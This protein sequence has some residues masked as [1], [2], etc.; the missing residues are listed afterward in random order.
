MS[1]FSFGLGSSNLSP[2][3]SKHASLAAISTSP[4]SLLAP[5]SANKLPQMRSPSTSLAA[6][7]N[8]PALPGIS[9]VLETDSLSE[10]PDSHIFERSVQD[11]AGLVKQEDY[12]PPALDATAEILS[13]LAT[14]LD[15]VE[16]VY[17]LRRNSSVIGL[18]MA[19]G[20]PYTP[21]RK[22][23][24]YLALHL[25]GNNFHAASLSSLTH[26]QP[27]PFQ[28]ASQP[29]SAQQ[30]QSPVSP[31]KL[32]SSRLSV[33]F[34][35]Y[36]DMINNDEFSRR[37]SL[38]HAYSHGVVP[39][40]GRK[41]SVASNHST[42]STSNAGNRERSGSE[43]S[44]FPRKSSQPAGSPPDPQSQLSKHLKDRLKLMQSMPKMFDE[45]RELSGGTSSKKLL[46]SPESSDSEDQEEAFH[47]ASSMGRKPLSRRKSVASNTSFANSVVDNDSF[48]S[49]SVGDCIRR[50]TTEIENN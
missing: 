40:L 48:V 19:L 22:N 14:D 10:N 50:C 37:P 3:P 42:L 24:V 17:A 21:L 43:F 12:I 30:A 2:A 16:M 26:L 7:P 49:S 39:S 38:M 13:D 32:M 23:S 28:S 25:N 8:Q 20:R 1:L 31:P 41:L 45:A 9:P 36:A 46:I 18:N 34:Y 27:Q 33:S 44:K 29:A 47:P 35:S 6:R 11:M 5:Q 4:S 15:N